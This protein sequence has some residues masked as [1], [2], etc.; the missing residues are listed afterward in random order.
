MTIEKKLLGISPSGDGA[1]DVAEVFNTHPYHGTGSAN[2]S[3]VNGIDLAGEGGLVWIKCRTNGFSHYLFD[4][5]RGVQKVISTDLDNGQ[6]TDSTTLT[7]FNSNGFTVGDSNSV[8]ISSGG[9]GKLVSWTFRKKKKF[10][11]IQEFSSN[12]G[13][14]GTTTHSHD[15]GTAPAMMI[16]KV[17]KRSNGQASGGGW[18]V[19]HKNLGS[20]LGAAYIL[21]NSNAAL[22]NL[23]TPAITVTDSQFTFRSQMTDHSLDHI[24]YLFA[25]NSS[26]D[27]EEQ[28]IKCG[29]YTGNGNANG[30]VVN[31]GWEPQFLLIKN[32]SYTHDWVI[33]DAM[34]GVV[35]TGD[36][37]FLRP[38]TSDVEDSDGG[39]ELNA[40]GFKI[41]DSSGIL[42]ENNNTFI[43]MAIRAPMMKEPEAATDVFAMDTR[44][45]SAAT[46]DGVV[47]HSNFPVDMTLARNVTYQGG[48]MALYNRSR[49]DLSLFTDT[50]AVEASQ[51]GSKWD[52]MHG[53]DVRTLSASTANMAWMW[54]KAK[55]FMDVVCYRG[56]GN[57]GNV[58]NGYHTHTIPH[59]LGVI[60]ELVIIK[61]RATNG[62]PWQVASPVGN[63]FLSLNETDPYNSNVSRFRN[64]HLW[65][66]TTFN[67]V[68]AG[69][70]INASGA[71]YVAQLFATLAGISKVGTFT[72]SGSYSQTINCGFSAGARF[73]MIKRTDAD[74]TWFMWDSVRG[75]ASGNEPWLG[76]NNNNAHT[77]NTDI[78][79]PHNSGFIIRPTQGQPNN[80]NVS[81]ATYLFYAIA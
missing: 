18:F 4:T 56:S 45:S 1:A 79:D 77:T 9:A 5:E 76:L 65:S 72:G 53:F 20:G 81:S 14:H 44:G 60:P 62:Q 40:T 38:N 66:D 16:V 43:Y 55:G 28:M 73:I 42:N 57:A 29:S 31:L 12:S 70:V 63:G 47:Y 80:M 36:D 52:S 17:I 30:P 75:I 3:I 71:Q 35:T 61:N 37:A 33:L 26:E 11:D 78:I 24:A 19:F 25:D 8:N 13:T 7:S 48:S 27:A 67:V 21:L 32:S 50:N 6:S 22:G 51:G 34:R 49:G 2:H 58:I 68:G 54:K 59:S 74:G 46:A 23:G 69:N 39:M 64:K 15:L 41:A 10:F